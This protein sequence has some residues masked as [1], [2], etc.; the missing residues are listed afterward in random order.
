[1]SFFSK[2]KSALFLLTAIICG[3]CTTTTEEPDDNFGRIR[4][5]RPDNVVY[6]NISSAGCELDV[7]VDLH[8]VAGTSTTMEVQ[9]INGSSR[10][11]QIH[12]WY[13]ID[14]YNFSIFYRRHPADR[15]IDRSMPFQEYTVAIPSQPQPHHAELRLNPGNRAQLTVALPFVEKLSPGE[16][17]VFEVYIATSLNTFKLK[18]KTFMVYTH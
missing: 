15:P 9:L 17:A 12:E 2:S 1:M 5:R 14:Q 4:L 10:K 6:Q 13:M 8:A 11:L 3:G 16:N 7:P 18:S